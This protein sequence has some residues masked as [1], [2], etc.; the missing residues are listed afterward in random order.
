MALEP[1][2]ASSSASGAFSAADRASTAGDEDDLPLQG[3][4]AAAAAYPEPELV[5]IASGI[6]SYM[7][8]LNIVSVDEDKSI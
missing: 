3:A 7:Y 5:S 4:A 8:K 6:D 2:L 1:D